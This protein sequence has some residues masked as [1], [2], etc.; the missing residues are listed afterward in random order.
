MGRAGAAAT[1]TAEPE[2][3]PFAHVDRSAAPGVL[4]DTLDHWAQLPGVREAKADSL[5]PTTPSS[6]GAVLDVGC[7]TGD[8]LA[9]WSRVTGHPAIGVDASFRMLTHARRRHPTAAVTVAHSHRLP[10]RSASFAAARSERLLI[11]D[12]NPALAVAEMG[13]VVRPGGR[14]VLVEPDLEGIVLAHPH[15]QLTVSLLAPWLQRRFATPACGR[16]LPGL[17]AGAGLLP[18]PVLVR[19]LP[20][21][22]AT[23]DALLEFLALATWAREEG[24]TTKEGARAWLRG[25]DSLDEAGAFVC[26][27]PIFIATGTRPVN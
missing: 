6:S 11:H 24:M 9:R 26:M 23:A 20:C 18:A 8:D 2:V 5:T 19:S 21:D 25:L 10:F 14:V 3:R 1:V 22:Y 13:R 7:G 27:V 4:I 12:T 15:P 16:G 17:L